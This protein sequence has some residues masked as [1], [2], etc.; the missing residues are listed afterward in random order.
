MSKLSWVDHLNMFCRDDRNGIRPR[1]RHPILE[2][3]AEMKFETKKTFM[4]QMVPTLITLLLQH[5]N[6][7][8]TQAFMTGVVKIGNRETKLGKWLVNSNVPEALVSEAFNKAYITSSSFEVTTRYKDLLRMAKSRHYHSCFE[9]VSFNGRQILKYL[10]DRDVALVVLR[11]SKGDFQARATIRLSMFEMAVDSSIHT[12]YGLVVNPVYGNGLSHKSIADA[13]PIPCFGNGSYRNSRTLYSATKCVNN[14]L[15]WHVYED[16]SYT[17]SS[18]LNRHRVHLGL[19]G[20][21]PDLVK[22]INEFRQW[23][24]PSRGNIP[25]EYRSTIR[26]L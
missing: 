15:K 20:T 22:K 13:L 16:Y 7:D 9:S 17:Y 5:N 23:W 18:V 14:R 6:V 25:C 8:V 24:G 10:E 19:L 4:P 21:L 1:R 12:F 3:L 11:D 2:A 26:A